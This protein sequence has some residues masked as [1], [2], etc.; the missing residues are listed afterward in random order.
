MNVV[1]YVDHG[2][3]QI[4]D[5]YGDKEMVNYLVVEYYLKGDLF[6]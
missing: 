4:I 2:M 6:Y 1:R 3:T 5:E